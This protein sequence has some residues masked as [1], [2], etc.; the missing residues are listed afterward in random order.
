MEKN[1]KSIKK[2]FG[3]IPYSIFLVDDGSDPSQL[4]VAMNLT[5]RYSNLTVFRKKEKF[6]IV[7]SLNQ[8]LQSIPPN[9]TISLPISAD[10]VFINPFL[11]LALFWAFYVR[12]TDFFFA[13]TV[14]KNMQ[15]KVTGITGWSSTKGLQ[16]SS[17]ALERFVEGKTRPSGWSVAFRTTTVKNYQ[18]PELGSLSDFYLNN[19][20]IL[21][22]QSYYWSKKVVTTLERKNSFSS[23]FSP[24]QNRANLL[25]TIDH[26][27]AQGIP[28][29]E[30]EIQKIL[31]TENLDL[32]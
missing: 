26:F 19:I 27:K 8:C 22:H 29:S 9:R 17:G 16:P 12:K 30:S 3:Q 24:Q 1:L 10:A 31:R 28:F 2:V 25:K 18:Y 14:H 5:A 4:A 20:M 13:K 6:G 11:P 21:T 32:G 23:S 7:S 15:N